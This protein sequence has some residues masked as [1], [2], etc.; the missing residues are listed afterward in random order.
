VPRDGRR[1]RRHAIG[2]G[3][4]RK[5]RNRGGRTMIERDQLVEELATVSHQT[6]IRQVEQEGRE[7]TYGQEPTPH[8]RERAEDIVQALELLGVYQAPVTDT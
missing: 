4:R 7:N 6:Y 2:V 5:H 3:Q 8:D 1:R